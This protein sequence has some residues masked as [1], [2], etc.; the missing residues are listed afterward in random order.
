MTS[1]SLD[2]WKLYYTYSC[3]TTL[4]KIM[5]EDVELQNLVKITVKTLDLNSDPFQVTAVSQNGNVCAEQVHR[6]ACTLAGLQVSSWPYFTL[7][8]QG[9]QPIRRYRNGD[10]IKVH[11]SDLY[12]S[13]WCFQTSLEEDL[14]NNDPCAAH[15]IFLQARHDLETGKLH[16]QDKEREKLERCTEND[17]EAEFQYTLLCQRQPD[18]QSLY[19][20]QCRLLKKVSTSFVML[21]T[22]S[23]FDVVVSKLGVKFLT[24]VTFDFTWFEVS[25]WTLNKKETVISFSYAPE[26]CDHID[27]LLKTDQA[28]FFLS[29]VLEFVKILQQEEKLQLSF[30]ADMIT[31]TPDGMIITWE[32]GV[33]DQAK[34]RN[35]QE[36]SRI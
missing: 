34:A 2:G 18:Y 23:M 10:F 32:N 24:E 1:F 13:K 22:D 14:I 9:K 17:I 4:A 6:K 20:H 5:A 8:E 19:I 12:L 15:L 30:H 7:L 25:R 26:I 21:T 31:T 36:T 29:G 11:G 3:F 27:I 16:L 28:E 33:Y 35:F